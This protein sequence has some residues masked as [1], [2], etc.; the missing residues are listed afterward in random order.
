MSGDTVARRPS[1]WHL[2]AAAAPVV[3]HAGANVGTSLLRAGYNRLDWSNSRLH[4]A[5]K[6]EGDSD[7]HRRSSFTRPDRKWK[8]TAYT[9]GIRYLQYPR[10]RYRRFRRRRT[11]RRRY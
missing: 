8:R 10:Y 9:G 11:Y 4:T 2:A 5:M 3:F 6:Q 7:R 1:G